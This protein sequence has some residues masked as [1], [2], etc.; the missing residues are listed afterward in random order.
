MIGEQHA[1]DVRERGL[2]A[3]ARRSEARERPPGQHPRR[4][5]VEAVVLLHAIPHGAQ[6]LAEEHHV[7]A[8][9]LPPRRVK[10][11]RH[12]SG[13]ASATSTDTTRP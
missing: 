11:R 6:P 13:A 8:E 2:H 4:R 7:V 1:V 12:S 9:R 10:R 3:V 5:R